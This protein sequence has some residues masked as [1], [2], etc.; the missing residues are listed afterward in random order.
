MILLILFM[1][2]GEWV[3]SG[4]PL[5]LGDCTKRRMDWLTTTNNPNRMAK[6]SETSAGPQIP[7]LLVVQ[8]AKAHCHTGKICKYSIYSETV[9]HLCFFRK[10]WIFSSI[11][12]IP[13]SMYE[14]FTLGRATNIGQ[15]EYIWHL[16]I[17]NFGGDK[18]FYS[19]W[20]VD[21]TRGPI[22]G[23]IEWCIVGCK[24]CRFSCFCDLY[25]DLIR[26]YWKVCDSL[27]GAW[28]LNT[29]EVVIHVHRDFPDEVKRC[30]RFKI[31]ILCPTRH[32]PKLERVVD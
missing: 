10:H 17:A 4:T 32:L 18:I 13:R 23:F 14:E 15:L 8:W 28:S 27:M 22:Y 1:S 16:E 30:W 29:L 2:S 12:G 5:R 25:K 31:S 11:Y 26:L 6:D 3:S 19:L 7:H 9:K 20:E 24:C 21:I